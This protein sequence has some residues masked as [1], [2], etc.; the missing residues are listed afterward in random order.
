MSTPLG[1][2]AHETAAA[3]PPAVVDA[4]EVRDASAPRTRWS[5]SAV[6]LAATVGLALSTLVAITAVSIGIARADV[7]AMQ[8]DAD[9]AP[10]AIALFVGLLL[11]GMGGLTAMMAQDRTPRG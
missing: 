2:A 6:E 8:A 1:T 4:S 9:G 3:A 7:P 5:A 11:S 10:L